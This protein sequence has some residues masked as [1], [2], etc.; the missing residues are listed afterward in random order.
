MINPDHI[1]VI[2]QINPHESI[3][4]VVNRLKGGTSRKLRKEFPE[5]Q[6]FIWGDS[7]WADG[8]FAESIGKVD[9]TVIN[10]YLEEHT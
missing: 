7:F 10:K 5:L 4:Q 2:I 3:A 8:Y 9:E 6:E 1:H